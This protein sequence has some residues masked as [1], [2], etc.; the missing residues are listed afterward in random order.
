M[1]WNNLCHLR[2]QYPTNRGHPQEAKKTR[3]T[4]SIPPSWYRS[5]TRRKRIK[6]K[7]KNRGIIWANLILSTSRTK[8]IFRKSSFHIWKLLPITSNFPQIPN[9]NSRTNKAR[10]G[11]WVWLTRCC[12]PSTRTTG[13]S[14]G[15]SGRSTPGNSTW[16][17]TN[18]SSTSK[19]A[20][21]SKKT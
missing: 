1:K 20:R 16:C 19:K 2:R 21:T 15:T 17:S 9:I 3:K 12:Q 6:R 8:K 7:M 18:T 5:S 10:R 11:A 13:N 4:C 14:S